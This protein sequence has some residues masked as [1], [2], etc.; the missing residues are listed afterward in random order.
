MTLVAKEKIETI[1]P[2]RNP[3][4]MIDEL[5]EQTAEQTVCAL[6]VRADNLFVEL[7][8]LQAPGIVEN[9]AQSAAARAGYHYW[10]KN[11]KP[12]IGFIGAISK[13]VIHHTPAVGSKLRTIITPKSEVFNITLVA[14]ESYVGNQKVAECEMKIVIN[15]SSPEPK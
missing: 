10:L 4:I 3:I 15:E 13:L 5:V 8:E 14:A 11:E 12:P 1:I 7:N 2:Q 9:I 6:E